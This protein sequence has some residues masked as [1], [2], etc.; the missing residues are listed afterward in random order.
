MVL[1]ELDGGLTRQKPALNFLQSKGMRGTVF[2]NSFTAGTAGHLNIT[3]YKN[4]DANGHTIGIYATDG[5]M[6]YAMTNANKE[7]MFI[8]EQNWLINNNLKKGIRVAAQSGVAG[9]NDVDMTLLPIYCDML[10]GGICPAAAYRNN[11]L[12][13][14]QLPVLSYFEEVQD[15]LTPLTKDINNKM[16]L[17]NLLNYH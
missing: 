8:R 5:N 11:A 6:W 12:W 10:L 15:V 4:L 3:D 1:F 9:V 16:L 2:A 13:N 17:I 7:A 14:L